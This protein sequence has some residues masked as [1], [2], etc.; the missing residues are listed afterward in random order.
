MFDLSESLK[1]IGLNGLP[2]AGIGYITIPEQDGVDRDEFVDDCYRSC[3]VCIAGVYHGIIYN[4]SIDKEV[5][6]HITFPKEPGKLGS[7]VVWVNIPPHNKPVV[8]SVLKYEDEFYLNKENEY[9]QSRGFE[10][11]DI[12]V[13]FNPKDGSYEIFVKTKTGTPGKINLNVISPDK[14]GEINLYV[15]GKIK[16]HS[17][18]ETKIV[19]DKKIQLH[20]VDE[21]SEDKCVITYERDLGF[22]Y[23][24]QFENEINIKEELVEIKSKKINHNSGKEPM[25]LGDS[26]KS[27]LSDILDA[28]NKITVPTALGPSGTPVNSAEFSAIKQRLDEIKS[29]ISN[30]E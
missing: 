26:L 7:P 1:P 23:I 19:S 27:I 16:L 18:E 9:N 28:I 13:R 11:N 3:Q 29:K 25:V 30:L 6:K 2:P 4:V 8:V 10:G 14:N 20:V 12:D 24:D 15:K 17:T 21:N 22:S 5:I